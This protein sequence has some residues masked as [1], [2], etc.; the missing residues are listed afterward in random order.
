MSENRLGTIDLAELKLWLL[1]V[2]TTSSHDVGERDRIFL[3]QNRKNQSLGVLLNDRYTTT[4]VKVSV[5]TS[6]GENFLVTANCVCDSCLT[7]STDVI[8]SLAG[9]AKANG[10]SHVIT[11]YQYRDIFREA[12]KQECRKFG[13]HDQYSLQIE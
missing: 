4:R 9:V 10:I 12:S 11:R 8:D 7:Y 3:L 6:N 5:K 1:L 2:N 13:W